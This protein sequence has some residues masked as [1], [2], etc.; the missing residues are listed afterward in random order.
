MFLRCV[1]LQ[2][3]RPHV[4]KISALQIAPFNAN[5]HHKLSGKIT[6]TVEILPDNYFLIS[7]DFVI[8]PGQYILALIHPGPVLQRFGQVHGQNAFAGSQVGDGAGQF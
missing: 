7:E 4:L 6:R 3:I 8:C 5:S 1:I 2:D